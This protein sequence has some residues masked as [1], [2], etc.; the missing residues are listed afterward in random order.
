MDV[1]PIPHSPPYPLRHRL[2]LSIQGYKD[3]NIPGPT[4]S[5]S[6]LNV[7]D[8]IGYIQHFINPSP[9]KN[10]A[11]LNFLHRLDPE[12]RRLVTVANRVTTSSKAAIKPSGASEN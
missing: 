12:W 5:V 7:V 1:C 11:P 4:F 6:R 3:K 2:R 9:G 8:F 10:L